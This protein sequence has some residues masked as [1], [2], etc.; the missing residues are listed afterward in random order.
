MGEVTH[1]FQDAEVAVVA[2]EAPIEV[3]DELH[4][5]GATDDFTFEVSSMEVDR[6]PVER[7]E[8]GDEVGIKVPQRA[9]E[10]SEVRRT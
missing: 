4:V 8:P 1:Y 10:G 3:G 7:V 2:V 6:E 5:D 9:R